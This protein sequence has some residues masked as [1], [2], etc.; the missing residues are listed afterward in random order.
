M[1]QTSP[2]QVLKNVEPAAVMPEQANRNYPHIHNFYLTNREGQ[3]YGTALAQRGNAL[4][5]G[6]VLVD[7][8]LGLDHLPVHGGD[9]GARQLNIG[10]GGC[11]NN[12]ART[13]KQLKIPFALRC[14]LGHGPYATIVRQYLEEEGYSP[15]VIDHSH[16]C[17]YCLCLVDKQGE[18]TFIVV[19]GIEEY[20]EREWFDLE[21]LTPADLIY[22]V[23]FDI[24]KG[25]G[26]H[27]LDLYEQKMSHTQIFFDAGSRVNELTPDTLQRLLALNPI[28]HLNRLELSLITQEDDAEKALLSL[29]QRCS[30][31]I[32]LTLDHE[33]CLVSYQGERVHFPVSVQSVVDATGAGDAHSAGIIAAL[34]CGSNL[35]TALSFGHKLASLALQ[36]VGTHITVP[37][38]LLFPDK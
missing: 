25:N 1:T 16:D 15:M 17:G 31:P 8:T 6:G 22:T 19:P 24:L 14:P 18:R 11:P 9:I 4:F 3:K 13:L 26:T 10:L 12:V 33:G 27:Y 21:D 37:T 2:L 7:V 35:P 34:L 36:Q 20:A 30:S 5:L 38:E 28:I 32:I 23:G 29:E